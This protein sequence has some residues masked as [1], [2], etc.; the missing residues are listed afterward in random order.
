MATPG[1]TNPLT[2]FRRHLL[3][4]WQS[5]KYHVH[6]IRAHKSA[7]VSCQLGLVNHAYVRNFSSLHKAVVCTTDAASCSFSVIR[8]WEKYWNYYWS[9]SYNYETL[10][11]VST[12]WK[13]Y[14]RIW[15]ETSLEWLNLDHRRKSYR[16]RECSVMRASVNVWTEE[17]LGTWP[18]SI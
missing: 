12:V 7:I 1:L 2:P 16:W 18:G 17:M 11:K 13:L 4:T 9:T 15:L 6:W 5:L 3:Q 8:R 14:E 10:D